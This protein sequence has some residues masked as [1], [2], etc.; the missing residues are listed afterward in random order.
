MSTNENVAQMAHLPET[1]FEA[2]VLHSKVPVLVV[3]ETPWSQPCQMLDP[4]VQELARACAGKAKIIKV[5]A[6]DCL[7]LSLS[8]EIQSIP[9]LIY[10]VEGKPV[11][12]IVGTATKD[13]ILAKL[14]PF[15]I[16]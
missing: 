8:Y 3:F 1:S 11:V 15:G 2:E 7:G 12:R 16:E 5:N 10:F 4:V 14:K 9:T 13:A 6:D